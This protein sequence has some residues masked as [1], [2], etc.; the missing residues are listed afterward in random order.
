M[1]SFRN[2][3]KEFQ[4]PEYTASRLISEA[5]ILTSY[6]FEKITAMGGGA[7]LVKLR[8]E[9]FK[10]MREE[11]HSDTEIADVF[12]TDASTIWR[13]LKKGEASEDR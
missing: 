11:G 12:N 13:S 2:K 3:M 4:S 8:R 9:I 10:A 5:V 6:P 7:R 1:T